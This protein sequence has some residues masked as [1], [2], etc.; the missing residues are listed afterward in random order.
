MGDREE[1]CE[2]PLNVCETFEDCPYC[3]IATLE[4]QLTNAGL[5]ED[6]LVQAVE[7][8]SERSFKL[9]QQLRWIP[10]SERLPEKWERFLVYDTF[11]EKHEAIECVRMGRMTDSWGIAPEG[12]NGKCP[13]ITHWKPIT[14]PEGE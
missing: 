13:T 14:P 4:H 5:V 6:Q 3:K 9:E 1:N 2:A 8:W 11:Y 12:M 7:T 10:V